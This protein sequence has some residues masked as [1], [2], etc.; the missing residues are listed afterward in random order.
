MSQILTI[1]IDIEAERGIAV[2]FFASDGLTDVPALAAVQAV[3]RALQRRVLR[4]EL[5]AERA[6]A[7]V[8]DGPDD[9]RP[10]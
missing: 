5:E 10:G 1:V 4:A 2:S 8:A 7:E 3:E 6:K 9:R